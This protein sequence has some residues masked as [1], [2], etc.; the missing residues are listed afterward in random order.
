M[1][2]TGYTGSKGR[3]SPGRHPLHHPISN[4]GNGLLR[5][6]SAVD[7]REVRGNL[8]V[9][10]PLRRSRDHQIIDSGDPPLPLRHDH[11]LE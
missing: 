2:I 1:K 7:L 6:L 9:G 4:S 8:T 11:R 5:H 10:Q 3:F